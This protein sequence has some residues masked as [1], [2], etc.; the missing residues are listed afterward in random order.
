M[1]GDLFEVG[2]TNAIYRIVWLGLVSLED[3]I[4]LFDSFVF[5]FDEA[6][7]QSLSKSLIPTNKFV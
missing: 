3:I 6:L 4:V 2:F 1:Y 5:P 7:S